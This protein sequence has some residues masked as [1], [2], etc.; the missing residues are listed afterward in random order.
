VD[1]LF[2]V[3]GSAAVVLLAATI[4]LGMAGVEAWRTVF[5][6]AHVAALIALAPLGVVVGWHG[7]AEAARRGDPGLGGVWR[8][9]RQVIF[10]LFVIA[11]AVVVSLLNFEDG[12]RGLRRAANY[13]T[14]LLSLVLVLRYLGWRKVMLHRED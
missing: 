10:V 9:Y 5:T 7:F 3:A 2:R 1:L 14:V 12:N 8:R 11:V 6:L 13:T 4:A